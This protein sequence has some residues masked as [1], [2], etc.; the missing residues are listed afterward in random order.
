MQVKADRVRHGGRTYAA[1]PSATPE[2]KQLLRAFG[3]KE[4]GD[5]QVMA[6]RL[7]ARSGSNTFFG[8]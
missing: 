3:L 5:E 7:V 4:L 8:G 1:Q 2:Q 6:K